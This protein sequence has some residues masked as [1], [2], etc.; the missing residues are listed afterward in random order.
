LLVYRNS[1]YI[2]IFPMR[3]IITLTLSLWE[4]PSLWHFPYEN[5]H[6]FDTFPMRIIITLTISLWELSSL[7]F[8]IWELEN[9]KMGVTPRKM[10]SEGV[11][12]IGK[13]SMWESAYRENA[14]VWSHPHREKVMIIL[15]TP[16]L[17]FSL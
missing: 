17:T 7:T 8:S 10:S 9:V 16:I 4:L 12:L 13:M 14:K 1:C 3:I 11:I 15:I 6:H 5:Y 2:V